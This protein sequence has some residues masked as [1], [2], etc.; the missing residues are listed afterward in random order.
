MKKIKTLF[1]FLMIFTMVLFV[2]LFS[3]LCGMS[4]NLVL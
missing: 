4:V 2:M 3:F 1:A